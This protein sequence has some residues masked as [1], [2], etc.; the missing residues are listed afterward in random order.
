[1]ATIFPI[2]NPAGDRR[3]FNSTFAEW[4]F[5]KVMKGLSKITNF[6]YNVGN[7]KRKPKSSI[8]SR[9]VIRNLEGF[10]LDADIL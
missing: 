10:W 6:T 1:M 9:N 8:W 5:F 2:S 3:G 7:C 4:I